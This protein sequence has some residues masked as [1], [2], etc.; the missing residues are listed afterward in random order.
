MTP[1]PALDPSADK[2]RVVVDYA[3]V[4]IVDAREMVRVV[5]TGSPAAGVRGCLRHE[6]FAR[7]ADGA[8]ERRASPAAIYAAQA[9]LNTF[10][11]QERT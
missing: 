3:G 8:F 1:R 5:F 10:Y 9:I 2:P 4:Q 6:G 7:A 11:S